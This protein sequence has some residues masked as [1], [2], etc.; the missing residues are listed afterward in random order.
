MKKYLNR[1]EQLAWDKLNAAIYAI[2]RESLVVASTNIL[3]V[4]DQITGHCADELVL[5]GH[6]YTTCQ[7]ISCFV[8]GATL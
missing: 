2:E 5:N 8:C 4:M 6:H 3:E 7:N 1:A